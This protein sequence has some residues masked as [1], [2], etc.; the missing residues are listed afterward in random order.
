MLASDMIQ[1]EPSKTA[2]ITSLV[3]ESDRLCRLVDNVL[4]FARLERKAWKVQTS[5]ISV[6]QLMEGIR[7]RC[8]SRVENA[9][10]ELRLTTAPHL[11]DK[12]LE[13]ASDVVEQI[14]FNLVENACKYA[15][16]P[17][18]PRIEV[19]ASSEGSWIL[20]RVR[21]FG[22]GIEPKMVKRLFRPFSRSSDE[23]AGTAA[24]VG[25]GLSLAHQLA[26]Q[27]RGRLEFKPGDPGSIFELW[28]RWDH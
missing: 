9:S 4:Q 22:P 7:T 6:V 26:R 21:D 15:T 12:K 28:L 11:E 24:G 16:D 17:L 19:S 1:D 18:V 14:V 10:K 5:N 2:Y 8:A 23:T 20:I 25:L 27:L 3:K 13:T